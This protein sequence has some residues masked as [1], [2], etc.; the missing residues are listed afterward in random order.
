MEIILIAVAAVVVLWLLLKFITSILTLAV[1]VFVVAVRA[2]TAL[3][4]G[5]ALALA[6][7]AD[8]VSRRLKP[9]G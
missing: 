2:L 6:W 7:A 8:K 5:I 3:L 1:D 4:D 9:P